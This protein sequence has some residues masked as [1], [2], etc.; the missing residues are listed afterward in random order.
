MTASNIAN[1]GVDRLKPWI[2]RTKALAAEVGCGD[3]IDG[4][5]RLLDDIDRD[6]ARV[7]VVG[8]PNAGKSR[9]INLILGA[10]I[11]PVATLTEPR[12]YII[13]AAAT[14]EDEGMIAGAATR[15]L[16]ELR[17]PAKL[18]PPDGKPT[19]VRLCHPW[20]AKN[21]VTLV[22]KPALDTTD[23]GLAETARRHL[24]GADVAVVVLDATTPLRR[25]E[26]QFLAEC[27]GRA[28]PTLLVL[29]KSDLISEDELAE[30]VAYVERNVAGDAGGLPVHLVPDREGK[31]D[32]VARAS[33]RSS[34]ARTWWRCERG[35]WQRRCSTPWPRL[36]PPERQLATLT[37]RAPPPA[38]W[39]SRSSKPPS[40]EP[41]SFGRSFN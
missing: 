36:A 2:I 6:S 13:E 30:V 16:A 17:K 33:S 31:A 41:T 7:I 22:E 27:L 21:R 40:N 8:G 34:R 18:G 37:R 28:M 5:L 11:L 32:E 19:V 25:T 39:R 23:A 14:P 26:Q 10:D 38:R 24:D 1:S 29:A 35:K 20:L 15:P 3:A 12:E 4:A 9:M